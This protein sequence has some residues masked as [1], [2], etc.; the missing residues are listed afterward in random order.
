[1]VPALEWTIIVIKQMFRQRAQSGNT[2]DDAHEY[3]SMLC[4]LL[5]LRDESAQRPGTRTL[6]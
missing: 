2:E 3:L 4:Q 1:M 6:T 5:Q